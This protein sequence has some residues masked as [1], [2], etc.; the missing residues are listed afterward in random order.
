MDEHG[1]DLHPVVPD[2]V[3]GAV[4][5]VDRNFSTSFRGYNHAEVDR[6]V[7]AT[8][9]RIVTLQAEAEYLGRAL[10]VTDDKVREADERRETA[11]A[12]AER[13]RTELA[14]LRASLPDIDGLR[15]RLEE[16]RGAY[17]ERVRAAEVVLAWI[18]A[19]GGELSVADDSNSSS[20][21]HAPGERSSAGDPLPDD[22]STEV[23]TVNDESASLDTQNVD[24]DDASALDQDI[25]WEPGPGLFEEQEN[26]LP[27]KGVELPHAPAAETRGA[28]TA[29][30]ETPDPNAV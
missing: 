19:Q 28:W 1:D 18:A 5:D 12:T 8:D 13:L 22:V 11:E 6:F 4:E 7:A 3:N 23:S 15:A 30:D 20:V 16:L 25:A 21:S 10:D 17:D 29:P 14:D 9:A 26:P 27:V 2:A 24:Y